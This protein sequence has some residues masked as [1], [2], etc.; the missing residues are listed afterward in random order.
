VPDE[1]DDN[2]VEDRLRVIIERVD[3]VP[4]PLLAAA[5]DSYTWRTVDS[6]L[7][8]L[9]LDSATEDDGALVRGREDVRLLSFSAGDLTIDIQ[10]SSSAQGR[11]LVGQ[12]APPRHGSVQIR[13]RSGVTD[14]DTDELG[15]F[16][17]LLRNGPFSLMCSSGTQETPAVVTDWITI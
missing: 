3:P 5:L 10:V 6:E 9:V 8:G 15:R 11:R 16:R 7:A 17:G 14:L 4:E 1:P 2:E 12:L 13:Q